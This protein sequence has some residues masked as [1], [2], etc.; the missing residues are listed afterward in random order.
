VDRELIARDP[1]QV[2]A[3]F[4]EADQKL[5]ALDPPAGGAGPPP[6][7]ICPDREACRRAV[8]AEA[9]AI[10]TARPELSMAALLRARLLVA[11]GKADEAVTLLGAE[12]QKVV[13]R[14]PCLQ[15]RVQAAAKVKGTDRL[16]DAAKDLMGVCGTPTI[17]AEMAN[18]VGDIRTNRGE[19]NLAL[20]MYERAARVDPAET[21]WLKLA[22]AAS[23]AGAHMRAA[24]ALEQV[25]RRRGGHDPKLK[26]RIED[27]QRRAMLPGL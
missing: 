22:D 1:A 8:L 20:V 12:C 13:D 7:E 18:W 2:N 5:K 17:C 24:D 15:G 6:A 14:L 10:A 25:A 19:V 9:E 4:R 16:T 3:H 23:A 11:D 27:E 26:Q 21:R